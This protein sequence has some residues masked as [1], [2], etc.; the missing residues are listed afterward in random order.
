MLQ[1]NDNPLEA[2]YAEYQAA[3][4]RA[5]PW[6]EVRGQGVGVGD[7]GGRMVVRLTI[8]RV[9]SRDARW[10]SGEAECVGIAC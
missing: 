4:R 1:L 7:T 9:D 5:L 2:S 6:L 10:G 8:T 3:V